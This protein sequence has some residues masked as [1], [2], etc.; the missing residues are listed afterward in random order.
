MWAKKLA[1]RDLCDLLAKFGRKV[2]GHGVY[3]CHDGA[4]QGDGIGRGAIHADDELAV[5]GASF[6]CVT[7][8]REAGR[9][10]TC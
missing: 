4:Q 8:W 5:Y 7:G 6:D 2:L 1:E 3:A 9:R 10:L